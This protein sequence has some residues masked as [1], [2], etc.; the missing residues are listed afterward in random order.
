MAFK[1][2]VIVM[3]PDGDP[4]RHRAS[5]K[6]SKLEL[7][8]VVIEMRNFDQAAKV[9]KDLVQK[10]GI[11]SFILCPGFTHQALA[12]IANAVGEKVAINVA[13][14]DVPGTTM[15]GEILAKEGW[16]SEGH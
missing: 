8:A 13:R 12:K 11:Q 5:I 6:T 10:E 16:F 14:G 15:V 4:N 2:A 3:A 7:T 9:C 1:E